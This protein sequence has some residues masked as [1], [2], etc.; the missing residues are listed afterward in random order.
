MMI[1]SY[2]A[3]FAAV[4]LRLWLPVLVSILGDFVRAYTLVAWLCRVPN[5]VVAGFI[6]GRKKTQ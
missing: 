2:T 3:C 4:T 6:T 5:I 1:F